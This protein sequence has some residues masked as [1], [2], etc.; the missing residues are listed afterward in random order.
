MEAATLLGVRPRLHIDG[1]SLET[2]SDVDWY[3][4]ELLRSDN[5]DV[6]IRHSAVHG[7]IGLEVYNVAGEKIAEG[8]SGQDR[9]VSLSQPRTRLTY[10]NT[11]YTLT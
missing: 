2:T 11:A 6:D 9:D 5:V 8:K 10:I 7:A 1:L 4:F 3:E